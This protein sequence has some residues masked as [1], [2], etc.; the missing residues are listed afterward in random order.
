M[1]K[2]VLALVLG[3][4]VLGAGP[5]AGAQAKPDAIGHLRTCRLAGRWLQWTHGVGPSEWSVAA[6]GAA[7]ERGLG[8]ATGTVRFLGPRMLRLDWNIPVGV[9]GVRWSGVYQWRLAD[10]N[11]GRGWLTFTLGPHAGEMHPSSLVRTD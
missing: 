5:T 8:N 7:W 11:N 9:G 1:P 10:C 2:T 3:G 6:S 4:C